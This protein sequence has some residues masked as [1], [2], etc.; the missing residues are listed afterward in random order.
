MPPFASHAER[1]RRRMSEPETISWRDALKRIIET[2]YAEDTAPIMLIE[3]V[4]SNAVGY[5]PRRALPL[6]GAGL[7]NRQTGAWR[8]HSQDNNPFFVQ[9]IRS[10]FDRWLSR[11]RPISKAGS[12]ARA[13]DFLSAKLEADHDL[14]RDNAWNACKGEFPRLSKRKFVSDVWPQARREAGLEPQAPAGRK[15]KKV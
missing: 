5:Y 1:Q 3:A 12:E 14:T 10:E 4:R 13:I 6:G 8:R 9:P 11:L 15:R 7:F 2:G